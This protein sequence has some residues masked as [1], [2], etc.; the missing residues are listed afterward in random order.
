VDLNNLS[1]QLTHVP[2]VSEVARKH[3]HGEGASPVVLAEIKKGDSTIAFLDAQHPAADT[4]S[5][6][7]VFFG[8]RERDA[9]R[10]G[11]SGK[12]K[13]YDQRW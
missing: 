12:K 5:F 9:V 7:Y 3:H 2:Y 11:K 10:E 13:R 6:T 4:S 1:L 8:F